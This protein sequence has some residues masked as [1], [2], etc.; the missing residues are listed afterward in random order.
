M[1]RLLIAALLCIAGTAHA[2]TYT[3]NRVYTAV[4]CKQPCAAVKAALWQRGA[5]LKTESGNHGLNT[6]TVIY[7]DANGVEV[8]DNGELIHAGDFNLP[9]DKTVRLI[10]ATGKQ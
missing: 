3:V 7:R 9:A 5:V 6:P 4:W 8:Y 2:A 1:T 10:E